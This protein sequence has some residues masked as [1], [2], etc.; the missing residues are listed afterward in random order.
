VGQFF[1][2]I[3]YSKKN[4]RSYVGQTNDL[5]ARLHRHNN[6]AVPSTRPCRPWNRI[7]HEAYKTRGEAMARER[8]LKSGKGRKVV[9]E[10]VADY[11]SKEENG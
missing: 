11:L 8:W 5:D 4:S 9:R 10:I 3:L 6:G 2:Y 7:H 1:V